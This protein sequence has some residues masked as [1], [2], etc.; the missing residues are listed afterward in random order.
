MDNQTTLPAFRLR[1]RAGWDE[2]IIV[3]TSELPDGASVDCFAVITDRYAILIDT[4]HR[5][6]TA[7]AMLH[8]L[9]PAIES[10]QL[11]VIN[12]H[13]DWDH[14]WGNQLFV[15]SDAPFPAPIIAHTACAER[16]RSPSAQAT[17]ARLQQRYGAFS[18]VRLTPPTVVFHDEL[19]IDGGDLTLHLFPTPG[20]TGDHIA[21]FIPEIRT[22]F[23]GDAAEYPFPFVNGPTGLEQLRRS[24]QRLAALEARTVLCCHAPTDYGPEI[25]TDNLN[26][27]ATLET[28]CRQAISSRPDPMDASEDIETLV[29]FSFDD[30]VGIHTDS[31]TFHAMYREGHRAAIHAMLAF[32]KT[33]DSTS[34]AQ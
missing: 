3:A 15:G 24:L 14:S 8:A 25:I 29:G 5:P 32:L 7:A 11:L 16:L 26:Y 23:A 31:T 13:A 10:R 2:R 18:S 1:P 17:L 27:F 22:L 9:R 30:A 28:R 12:S 4:F 34:T 21:V 19:I 20:H 33:F 6:E